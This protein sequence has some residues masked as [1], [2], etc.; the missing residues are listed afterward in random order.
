M[1]TLKERIDKAVSQFETAQKAK[2]AADRS[3]EY[4]RSVSEIA[5]RQREMKDQS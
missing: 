3:A 4:L 5:K 2:K 1:E